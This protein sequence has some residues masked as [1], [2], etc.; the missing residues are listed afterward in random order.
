MGCTAAWCA[1]IRDIARL[2]NPLTPN[3]PL[4]SFKLS[5]VKYDVS[6]QVRWL[7]FTL[8]GLSRI[9]SNN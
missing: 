5:G 8:N 4:T 2:V 1:N 9:R 3:N 6:R 7:V